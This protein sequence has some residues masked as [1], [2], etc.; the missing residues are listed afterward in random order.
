MTEQQIKDQRRQELRRRMAI[1]RQV[2]LAMNGLIQ[3]MVQLVDQQSQVIES[4]MEK[5]QIKNLLSTALETP[6]VEVVKHYVLYQ[7][8]R[9]APGSSWRKDGFGKKLVSAMDDLKKRADRITRQVHKEL[10]LSAP[11]EEQTD[12]TWMWLVRAYLGQLN[13]YFYYRKEGGTPWPQATS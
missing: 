13:R 6:S 4:R 10:R 9:D 12:E 5:H 2:E 8:G 7:V 1:Q 11:Q 3:S